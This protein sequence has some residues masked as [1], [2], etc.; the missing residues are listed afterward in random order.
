[1]VYF[2]HSGNWT[3]SDTNASRSVLRLL[4][5]APEGILTENDYVR[6]LVA[7][8]SEFWVRGV[9]GRLSEV[10]RNLVRNS[11][12]VGVDRGFALLWIQ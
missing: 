8:P 10:V 4:S 11:G 12:I 6:D 2:M 5:G 7:E 9:G 3:F 1:M